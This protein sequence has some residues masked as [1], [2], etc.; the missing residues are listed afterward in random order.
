MGSS[1]RH[2]KIRDGL[3]HVLPQVDTIRKIGGTAGMSIGV[4]YQGE[5]ILEHSLGFANLETKEVANSSTRYT[6]GSLTKGFVAA[7]IAQL[8]DEGLLK[9]DEPL[10]SYIPEL[11]FKADPSL[12]SRLTLVDIL[13][14]NTGLG[15]L[16]VMWLGAN[17][18]VLA[19]KSSLTTMLNHLPPLYPLRSK[20]LY[21]NWMYALAGE[22]AERV[23]HLPFGEVLATRVLE[24]VG[25]KETTIIEEKVPP[26]STALPYLVLDDKSPSKVTNL[27][28]MSGTLMSPAGGVKSTLHDML[29]WGRTILSL[30][31]GKEPAIKGLGT[32]LSGHSFLRKAHG[33]DELYGLGFAKVITPAQFGKIGFNPSLL[34]EGM[35]DIGT[36]SRPYQIFY[37]NGA[38]TGYNTCFMLIPELQAV[39][40]VLTNSISLGDTADWAAQTILQAVLEVPSPRDLQ[41]LA[42]RAAEKWSTIHKTMAKTLE[43]GQ[44]PGT[45]EPSHSELL[46][47]YWHTTK[48]MSLEVFEDGGSLK[49]NINGKSTQEHTL[50]HYHHDS[51][52][53]L[54]TADERVRRGLFH[55]SANAWLL[56][57]ERGPKGG[58]SKIVWNMDAQTD[59]GEEFTRA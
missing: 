37:H 59:K 47:T 28:S 42:E 34:E 21:N 27:S 5:T 45:K 31:H 10:S 4:V 3:E 12:S 33:F 35:P 14:H 6:I 43:E 41:P 30:F 9:W 8:V 1:L 32:I 17:G 29:T 25:L 36:G 54:P 58:F 2:S 38:I 40:T 11:S 24:K 22:I 13:S 15:R 39:I 20:W 23:T 7:T 57:F 49:F 18:E 52:I 53:F 51:F 44:T 16:D 46:G 48:V 26:N 56:H 50:S 55:Y 19:P